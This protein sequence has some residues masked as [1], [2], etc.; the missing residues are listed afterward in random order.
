V[1]RG[2]FEDSRNGRPRSPADDRE[3]HE[4]SGGD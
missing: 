1:I 4:D 2:R 3:N